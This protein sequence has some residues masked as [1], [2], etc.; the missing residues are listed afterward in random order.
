[1]TVEHRKRYLAINLAVLLLALA[2]LAHA[3]DGRLVLSLRAQEL[4]AFFATAC[5]VFGLKLVRLYLVFVNTG[6][7]FR[8]HALQFFK[9]LLVSLVLPFKLGDVFRVYCY[10]T[11]IGNFLRSFMAVLLDRF[12]D[13]L[14]LV[15]ILLALVVFRSAAL[16][17]LLYVLGAFL[18]V[19]MLCYAAF[20]SLYAYWSEYLLRSRA[21]MQRLRYLRFLQ[22]TNVLYQEFRS[23]VQGRLLLLFLLSMLAW[24]AELFCIARFFGEDVAAY[25]LAA[26]GLAGDRV[27]QQFVL[28]GILLVLAVMLLGYVLRWG[29]RNMK[30]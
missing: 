29:R 7:R 9:T 1:M 27:Q 11:H 24:T 28:F 16:P 25:L 21:T 12:V 14:A 8:T 23:V 6:L 3:Y 30:S 17:W 4:S 5:A 13:T 22:Q 26:A 15:C 18:L 10:G 19:V 2:V 20:P